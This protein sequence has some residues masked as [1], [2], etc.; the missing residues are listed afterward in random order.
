MCSR[1]K[2][3]KLQLKMKTRTKYIHYFLKSW[4]PPL[5]RYSIMEQLGNVVDNLGPAAGGPTAPGADDDAAVDYRDSG[6]VMAE[7][8]RIESIE[9]LPIL[10]KTSACTTTNNIFPFDF[11]GL[12]AVP[13]PEAVFN[14][15][16]FL[17]SFDYNY[18]ALPFIQ[19]KRSERLEYLVQQ[20]RVIMEASLPIQCVEA[21]FLA[22]YCTMTLTRIERI[23]LSLK[24][25]FGGKEY[26]HIVLAVYHHETKKWGSMGISRRDTL[27]YKPLVFDS[28]FE[29]VTD[30]KTCYQQCFHHML[31]VYVGL[32]IPHCTSSQL[33]SLNVADRGDSNKQLGN[34]KWRA[35]KV[36]VYKRDIRLVK[37]RLSKFCQQL[38]LQYAA[39]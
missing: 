12:E 1:Y 38:E 35:L 24:S 23:P 26:R 36:R 33:L 10:S 34:I 29:L 18:L 25:N 8:R 3:T 11:E 32:P 39:T 6:P 27:M 22:A 13:V 31:T 16:Q 7:R 30:L 20:S 37:E 4:R 14:V 5:V 15:Q 28:L 17:E 21:V 19:L 9:Y 2:F